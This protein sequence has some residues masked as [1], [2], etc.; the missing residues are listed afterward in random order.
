MS[1]RRIALAV[2]LVLVALT[3]AVVMAVVA[4]GGD[5]AD[6]GARGQRSSAADA[7][8]EDHGDHGLRD[9][10][11]AARGFLAGY[12]PLSY[13]KAGASAASVP[14]AAPRLIAR[15]Q[16]DPGRVSP[17]QASQT[18]VVD[19]VSVIA[20]GP[21]QALATAQIAQRPS[22]FRYALIFRLQLDPRAGWIVTRLG[23]G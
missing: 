16:A 2:V 19:V 1:G 7:E 10:E 4:G 6:R 8:A 23:A 13:G 3:A 12:L 14:N 18:P 20:T 11:R 5:P 17:A 22:R 21:A 9:A 15:L